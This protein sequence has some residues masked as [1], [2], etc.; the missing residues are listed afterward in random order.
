MPQEEMWAH[1]PVEAEEEAQVEGVLERWCGVERAI[2][3][4][5]ELGIAI[6]DCK[7]N[8]QA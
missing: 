4:R 8:S 5:G 1:E 6:R 2:Y 3:A 7:L